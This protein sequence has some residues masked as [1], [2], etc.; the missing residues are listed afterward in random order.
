MSLLMKYVFGEIATYSNLGEDGM[1][2][3]ISEAYIALLRS[4]N[5]DPKVLQVVDVLDHVML[6]LKRSHMCHSSELASYRKCAVMLDIILN[7]TSLKM[8]DG[9]NCSDATKLIRKSKQAFSDDNDDLK[10]ITD[11]KIDLII[12]EGLELGTNEWKTNGTNDKLI[13]TLLPNFLLI[14]AQYTLQSHC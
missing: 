2:I 9:E 3:Q 6:D 1:R 8:F 5:Y 10:R 11:R 14:C 13:E 4:K 7:D 12:A